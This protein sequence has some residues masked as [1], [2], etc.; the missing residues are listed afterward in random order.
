MARD[1]CKCCFSFW[2]I[3]CPLTSL[4]AQKVNISKIKK[5]APGDIIILHKC[6]KNHDHMLYC[7]WDMAPDTFNCFSFWEF[8]PFTPLTAQKNKISK[9]WKKTLEIS[10]FY[11]CV[12]KNIIIW[13][14]V[15][16][17]LWAT[18]GR[19]EKVTYRGE[20]PTQKFHDI[21]ISSH[22]LLL[23]LHY[24]DFA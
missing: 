5:K 16:E 17:I 19:T 24:I 4:A 22:D 11:T 23:K 14:T 9:K 20:C 10:S 18:G 7:P 13:C 1:G 15:P 3:S 2:A 6:T 12:P 8:F 21:E